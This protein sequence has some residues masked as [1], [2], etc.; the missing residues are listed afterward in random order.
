MLINGG[1]DKVLI[2]TVTAIEL[3]MILPQEKKCSQTAL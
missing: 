1:Q 2:V 3:S